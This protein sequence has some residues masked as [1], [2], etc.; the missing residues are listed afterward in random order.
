VPLFTV[1]SRRVYERLGDD[2]TNELVDLFNM[3][4]AERRAEERR[5]KRVEARLELELAR[6]QAAVRAS[7]RSRV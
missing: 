3:F 6:V 2:V 4:D 1:L 5:A 7:P